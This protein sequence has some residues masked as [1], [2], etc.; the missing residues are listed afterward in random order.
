[1]ETLDCLHGFDLQL[2][3]ARS[4]YRFSLD[5]LLLCAFAE[6]GKDARVIDLGTGSGIVPQLLA[7]LNKGRELVGVDL[8][9]DL[10]ERAQRS[11]ALNGLA[12]RVRIEPG[13]VRALP[14]NWRRVASIAC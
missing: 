8:Q 2:L 1:M 14:Q 10:V 11:V 6:I 4:G 3:Q 12:E 9:V 7:R 5:P 13:D